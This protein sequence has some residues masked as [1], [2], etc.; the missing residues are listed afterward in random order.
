[1]TGSAPSLGEIAA[2]V[3]V[4]GSTSYAIQNKNGGGKPNYVAKLHAK[5][6]S[7]RTA[8]MTLR[9]R[10]ANPYSIFAAMS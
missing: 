10:L 4:G 7:G 3:G 5:L 6:S 1:M 2:M 9:L 8:P